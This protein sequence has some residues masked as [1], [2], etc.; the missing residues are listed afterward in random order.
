MVLQARELSGQEA[1][2]VNSVVPPVSVVTYEVIRQME[3]FVSYSTKTAV[4]V[5]V[6]AC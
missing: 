2:R 1:S 6:S 4:P 3:S 5:P